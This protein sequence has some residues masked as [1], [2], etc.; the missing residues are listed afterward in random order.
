MPE[1]EE[2]PPSNYISPWQDFNNVQSVQPVVAQNGGMTIEARSPCGWIFR[3]PPL[4][5]NHIKPA[6]VKYIADVLNEGLAL[7]EGIGFDGWE[8]VGAEE[9]SLAAS[10]PD[11]PQTRALDAFW[12]STAPSQLQQEH[13][14]C[15]GKWS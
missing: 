2:S 15:R 11:T 13:W 3:H 10:F 7:G 1:P 14:L 4:Q 5:E 12:R 8:V 6:D 9:G